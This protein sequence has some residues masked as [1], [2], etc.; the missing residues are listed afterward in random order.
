MKQKLLS[1]K[2]SVAVSKA[3]AVIT[4]VVLGSAMMVGG[5]GVIKTVVLPSTTTKVNSMFGMTGDIAGSGGTGGGSI[6][7]DI[8]P[9][10]P[11]VGTER[12]AGSLIPSGG[13]YT[14]ADGTV[15]IS[16]GVNKFP[17]TASVGD[18]YVEDG[19]TYTCVP[20]SPAYEGN[21]PESPNAY[22]AWEVAAEEA[23]LT[24]ICGISMIINVGEL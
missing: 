18:I 15:L 23:K 2:A 4:A 21:P 14:K 6:G 12:A 1:K 7:D 9:V 22:K 5:A 13:K 20:N 16:N 11:A 8:S 24:K 3:I 19:S 17:D 10:V